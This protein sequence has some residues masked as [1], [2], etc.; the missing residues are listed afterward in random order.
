M[1]CREPGL[2]PALGKAEG[3]PA[4]LV[5]FGAKHN[6]PRRAWPLAGVQC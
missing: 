1:I 3:K 4:S 2:L 6:W 5:G